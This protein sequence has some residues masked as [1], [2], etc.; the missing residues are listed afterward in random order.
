MAVKEPKLRAAGRGRNV[1]RVETKQPAGPAVWIRARAAEAW[2]E[3]G[4]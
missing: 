2:G 4:R 3:A 1:S